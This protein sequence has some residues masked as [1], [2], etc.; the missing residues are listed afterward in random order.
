MLSWWSTAWTAA[1]SWVKKGGKR[2]WNRWQHHFL[3]QFRIAVRIAALVWRHNIYCS[4]IP[5]AYT[6]A[7][8]P[9]LPF[10][11]SRDGQDCAWLFH[12]KKIKGGICELLKE[13][14]LPQGCLARAKNVIF[15]FCLK[16]ET[17]KSL[18]RERKKRIGSP[19]MH[20]LSSIIHSSGTVSISGTAIT[21]LTLCR[22]RSSVSAV[23]LDLLIWGGPCDIPPVSM[24]VSS[25]ALDKHTHIQ[26]KQGN[27]I[28]PFV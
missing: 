22:G 7:E 15:S 11:V 21:F 5:S 25:S 23:C 28:I 12:R 18:A 13:Y 17:Y 10:L 20:L 4:E 3:K 1:V 24:P 8:G 16:A 6:K 27:A 9:C 14:D 19:S 26:M 2:Q